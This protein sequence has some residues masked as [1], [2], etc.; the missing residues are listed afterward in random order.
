MI[1]DYL[2]SMTTISSKDC[3]YLPFT[4]AAFAIMRV[5]ITNHVLKPLSLL[6]EEKN[7]FKFVHRG[8][9]CLHYIT[10]TILGTAAFSQRPYGHCSFWFVG[11]ADYIK[12]TG[13]TVICSVFEK[14][15]YLYFASYYLSDVFWIWTTKDVVMLVMHHIVSIT[16]LVSCLFVARHMVGFCVMILSDWVDIFL[17]SGKVT[18]YLGYKKLSDLLMVCFATAFFYFRIFGCSLILKA[19]L[20]THLEQPHHQWL[21]F[22]AKSAFVGLCCCNLIWEYQIIMALKRI[23]FNNDKIH[24]TRSDRADGKVQK[25]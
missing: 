8:F 22:A 4:I 3:I 9:D 5:T 7:R 12:C 25:N 24:D 1:L 10:S 13:D 16:M 11:C 18:N 19:V 6:I 23:F 14:V 15:Y 17:Y 20:T 2:A 21:W